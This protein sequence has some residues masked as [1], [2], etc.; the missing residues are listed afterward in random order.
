MFNWL[1]VLLS[2]KASLPVSKTIEAAETLFAPVANE[3]ELYLAMSVQDPELYGAI[4]NVAYTV[5]STYGGVFAPE[6]AELHEAANALADRL[7]FRQVFYAAAKNMM[8]FG[9]AVF[10]KIYNKA[11]KVLQLRC[12]PMTHLTILE[13]REQISKLDA[14]IFERNLYCLN[15]TNEQ[16]RKIWPKQDIV[17]FSLEDCSD[18]VTDILGRYTFGVWSE[19]PLKSLKRDIL[20]K[21]LTILNDMKWRQ[22]MVPRLHHKLDLSAFRPEMFPAATYEEKYSKAKAAAQT[23]IDSYVESIKAPSPEQDYVTGQEVEIVPI[24]TKSM[25]VRDPNELVQQQN[26]S[27]CAATGVPMSALVGSL[28]GSYAS[29][30]IVSSFATLR[31]RNIAEKI[32]EILEDLLREQL[33]DRFRDAHKLF[34]KLQLILD[35]DRAELAREIALLA[36][37]NCFTK[38]EL[39]QLWGLP[40]LEEE[41]EL[42]TSSERHLRTP[43]QVTATSKKRRAGQVPF[44]KTEIS[45]EAVQET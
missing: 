19:S 42:A 9:D 5:A 3:K 4:R 38:T 8:R 31:A 41:E 39:R 40:P 45:K 32:K 23:A 29:E 28:R 13:S 33:A 1:R 15:E 22:K 35:K 34:I 17:H 25:T 10:E 18:A 2:R 6:N 20:W 16:K 36:G 26:L 30:L 27:I 12:L 7:K 43:A 21:H 14:Q 37:T 44:P 24:E 11:G